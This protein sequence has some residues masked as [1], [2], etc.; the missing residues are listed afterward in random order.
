MEIGL[1]G[2]ES[3]DETDGI[4]NR[5]LLPRV[6]RLAEIGIRV[7][8]FVDTQVVAIFGSIVIGDGES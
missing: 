5:A 3:S 4:F 2:E 6:I 7:E 1:F 8:D